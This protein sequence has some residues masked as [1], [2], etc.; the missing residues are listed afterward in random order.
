MSVEPEHIECFKC[1]V[2]GSG[3]LSTLFLDCKSIASGNYNINTI[4]MVEAQ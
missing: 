3:V 4:N 2:F 1:L